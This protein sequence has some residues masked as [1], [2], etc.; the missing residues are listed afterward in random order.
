PDSA[1]AGAIAERARAQGR[2]DLSASE[3][4]SLLDAF[5]VPLRDVPPGVLPG[6]PESRPMAI[7][8][9]RD[10]R[11]GPVIQFGAG[12]PDAVLASGT[13]RGMDPPPLNSF[14]AR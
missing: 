7:R 9:R 8:V 2:V 4:R 12:G 13:D 1:R 14:L 6:G 10:P 3:C 5:Y 11:F